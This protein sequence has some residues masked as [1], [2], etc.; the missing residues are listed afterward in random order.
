M[1]AYIHKQALDNQRLIEGKIK[2]SKTKG[3][4]NKVLLL[5]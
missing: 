3:L 1:L 2:G 4:A 5:S